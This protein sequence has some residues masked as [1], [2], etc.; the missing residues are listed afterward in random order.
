MTGPDQSLAT[1]GPKDAIFYGL[2]NG[3]EI[4]TFEG[5]IAG[6]ARK[7]GVTSKENGGIF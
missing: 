2:N 4:A 3:R 6:A 1:K 5:G 7:E